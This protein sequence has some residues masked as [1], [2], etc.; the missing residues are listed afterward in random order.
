M[1]IWSCLGTSL[2]AVRDALYQGR[3][4]I[5]FSP[6]RKKA[7]FRSAL[8][9]DVPKADL[10]PYLD[11]NTRQLM[12][13]EAQYAYMATRQ[14]LIRPDWIRTISTAMRWDSSMATTP[15]LRLR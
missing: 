10:K 13:E 15:W 8:C 6:E 11:R 9:A 1:G 5:I 2:E 14:A 3:S 7:G 4:G 12:P